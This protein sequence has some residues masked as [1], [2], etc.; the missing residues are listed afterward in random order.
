LVGIIKV[1]KGLSLVVVMNKGNQW[2]PLSTLPFKCGKIRGF[3]YVTGEE[4]R[5]SVVY[6]RIKKN[7]SR[8]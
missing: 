2:F 8:F 1:L 7:I 5:N 6:L 3:S 4:S